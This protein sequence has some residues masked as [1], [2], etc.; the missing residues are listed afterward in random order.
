MPDVTATDGTDANDATDQVDSDDPRQERPAP[1]RSRVTALIAVLRERRIVTIVAATVV[2][3]IVYGGA[4][5]MNRGLPDDVAVR[6]G[7]TDVTPAELRQRMTT[8]EALYGVQVPTDGDERDEFWRDAAQS[9]VMAHVVGEAAREKDVSI[10]KGEV[11]R[12][13]DTFVTRVFGE[14]EQ[15]WSGFEA[16]LGKVGTSEAEVREEIRRQLELT[17]LFA[18]VTADVASPTDDDVEQAYAD[19]KCALEIAEGRQISNIV[20]AT[21]RDAELAI[22]R[23]RAGTQ[24]ATVASEVSID[25][26]TRDEGGDLGMLRARDLTGAYAKV[27]FGAAEGKL[28]GPVQSE[29]GWNVGVVTAIEAPRTPRLREIRGELRQTLY[30][31]ERSESWQA[32]LRDKVET[33]DIEYHDDYRPDD[34]LALPSDAKPG[35]ATDQPAP[36]EDC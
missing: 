10:S 7:Q 18:D 13:L 20:V 17:A 22:R 1:G 19:R 28:F 36:A 33:A 14:G 24:F 2:V 29:H 5:W 9:V 35:E 16:A 26:S 6:I 15:G 25:G 27:A 34:P 31:E 3:V 23:L 8:V 32:W 4:W 21:K 30:A 12:S 11:D